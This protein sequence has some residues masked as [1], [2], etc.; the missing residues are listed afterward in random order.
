MRTKFEYLRPQSIEDAVRMKA[1]QGAVYWA[2]GTDLIL[3]WR[4]GEKKIMHCVDLSFIPELKELN[5]SDEELYIGA[6]TTLA[7]LEQVQS[8]DTMMFC[9]RGAIRAMCTPQLRTYAT[10]G[11]NLCNASPAADLSVLFVALGAKAR[12]VGK[13]GERTILLED[14]FKGVNKTDLAEDELLSAVQIPLPGLKLSPSFGR[15]A[16]TVVDIAQV[17]SAVCLGVDSKGRVEEARVSLGAVAPTPIRSP[18]AEKM[19]LATELSRIDSDLIEKIGNRAA[20]DAKPIDDI[21]ASAAFRKHV[22]EV[23]VKRCVAESIQKL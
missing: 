18:E 23:L 3:Q 22:I 17:N 9:L 11:G 2:G 19:L 7:Q 16:R 4:R 14:F 8:D 6:M 1:S 12:I 10:V 20:A 21:R 15:V 13:D 5:S